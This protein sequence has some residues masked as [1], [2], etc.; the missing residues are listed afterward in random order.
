MSSFLK[1]AA[2]NYA[3]TR[4]YTFDKAVRI[5]G[6]DAETTVLDGTAL[7]STRAL[8]LSH[9]GVC[10]ENLTISNCQTTVSGGAVSMSAGTIAG[11][12]FVACKTKGDNTSGGALYK[13]GGVVTNCLFRG[14]STSLIDN[15]GMGAAVYQSSGTLVGCRFEENTTPWKL[16]YDGAVYAAGGTVENCVFTGN[17]KTPLFN[18]GGTVV[19]CLFYGNRCTA[20]RVRTEVP[21]YLAGVYQKSGN[22]WNCTI[23]CNTNTSTAVGCAGLVAVGGTVYN[24]IVCDCPAADGTT[25]SYSFSGVTQANNLLDVSPHFRNAAKGDFRLASDSP[26]IDAGDWT[27]LGATKDAVRA[28]RDLAGAARLSGRNVDIGCYECF[29]GGF[30]LIVR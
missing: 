21:H 8:T 25:A 4:A 15:Y 6:A 22:L 12:W 7:S 23:A 28:M 13:T 11:C 20:V 30:T 14:C 17:T 10:L 9:A 1:R 16:S 2:G 5:V 29:R 3:L 27:R 19:N 24:T 18:N 26:A